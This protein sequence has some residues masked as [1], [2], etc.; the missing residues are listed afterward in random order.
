MSFPDL[1]GFLLVKVYFSQQI[2][3]PIAHEYG[4]L[5][6]KVTILVLKFPPKNWAEYLYF[7]AIL[8]SLL[9]FRIFYLK[10]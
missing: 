7:V 3:T 8:I 5:F 6:V 4:S 10:S 1:D 2:H 9:D